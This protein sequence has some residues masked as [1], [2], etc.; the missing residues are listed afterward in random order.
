MKLPYYVRLLVGWLVCRSVI[1]SWKS[2]KF[3]IHAPAE[4]LISYTVQQDSNCFPQYVTRQINSKV[5]QTCMCDGHRVGG[6]GLG[7]VSWLNGK[8]E[9]LRKEV[10]VIPHW[11]FF[12]IEKGVF[13]K[14]L[15]VSFRYANYLTTQTYELVNKVKVKKTDYL[16]L[17]P[18]HFF[19]PFLLRS[20]TP[21]ACY[22]TWGFFLQ[23]Y[24]I[25]LF[26]TVQWEKLFVAG[27]A[28]PLIVLPIPSVSLPK[29]ER[30]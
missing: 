3:Y 20:V 27:R 24:L 9:G 21:A 10:G 4:A 5:I 16:S 13:E 19:T 12:M 15:N 30:D 14:L 28:G 29:I 2:W 23:V 11:I 6:A 17:N 25:M 1:I 22:A 26:K 7:R 8:N 18:T